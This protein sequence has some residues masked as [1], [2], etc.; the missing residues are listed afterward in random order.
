MIRRFN[1]FELKY[2][3][4]AFQAKAFLR[5]AAPFMRPDGHAG[6]D[7]VYRVTSLYFDG[8]DFRFYREKLEGLKAR[9]KVRLR[10]YPGAGPVFEGMVEIKQ[11]F[12]LIVLKRRL[13]LPLAAAEALCGGGEPPAGLD[14]RDRAVA[15]EVRALAAIHDLRPA[16][17][18]SYL[19]RPLVGGAYD[20]GLRVTVDSDLKARTT[21]LKVDGRGRDR[22]FLPPAISVLEV[23]V[24]ERIPRWLASLLAA[25]DFS[26]R[27]VSKYCSGL[28][29]AREVRVRERTWT[30]ATTP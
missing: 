9:T 8:P 28:E 6:P 30:G 13:A 21:D 24:N 18:I 11:R 16:A 20:P 7:G 29:R 2:V 27:R 26:V 5:D 1:R 10:I 12:N 19:R 4:D 14:P 25:H 3:V 23:K 15:E 22:H 17:V